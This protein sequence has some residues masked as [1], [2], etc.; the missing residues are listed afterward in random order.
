MKLTIVIPV[1]NTEKT[2]R[3]CVE[4]VLR[5][6]YPDMEIILVDDESPDTCPQ[7]CNDLAEAD[8]RIRVVHQR[9]GGLG[10]ARN[11]GIALAEGEYITFVD[12]DDALAPG[13]LAGLMKIIDTHPEYDL[14]EFPIAERIGHPK[15]Q[16]LLRFLQREYNDMGAYWL[17]GRA[18]LHAY[19][20]NKIYRRTLFD[21]V[22]FPE[23]R[24]FEDM[25]TLPLLLKKCKL[26]ATT[27]VGLY[28]YY[29]NENG[30]TAQAAPQDL[31]ALLASHNRI[32]SQWHD[33]DYYAHVLN[34]ALDVY[35]LSGKVPD[36]VSLPYHGNLKLKLKQLIG[37]KNLCRLHRI[38]Q[39]IR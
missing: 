3:R 13:T 27:P 31:E 7:I 29:Y 2:L 19:A 22:R 23:G 8:A 4:S 25:A 1:F 11:T 10:C 5:Q 37:L 39:K 28:N 14:L 35:A 38:F 15:K 30:I 26:V 24:N 16:R 12:S 33:E 9:H 21:E 18:Y 34:I 32:L 6:N 20:C 17:K 36:M